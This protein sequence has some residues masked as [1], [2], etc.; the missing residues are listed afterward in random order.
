M[1]TN[2]YWEKD[3]A[4]PLLDV[5]LGRV[6]LEGLLVTR[7]GLHIG[8]GGSGDPMATDA[9][10][11]R[12]AAGEPFIP[13]SSLKGVVRS[14][15]ESLFRGRGQGGPGGLWSCDPITPGKACLTH[16][17]IDVLRKPFDR[18]PKDFD[19]KGFA[20]ALWDKSC[21][22]CRLFGS[23]G[24]AGRVRFPDLPLEGEL[25]FS[26]LRNGVGIDRDKELAAHGVL[27]DFEAI[28]PGTGFGLTVIVDNPCDAEIGLLLYLFQQLHEGHLGLGGKST[29]GLGQV[30]VHW[31][32]FQHITLEKGNPFAELVRQHTTEV[33]ARSAEQAEEPSDRLPKTGD[34]QTWEKIAELLPTLSSIDRFHLGQKAAA[35]GIDKETL[36]ETLGIAITGRRRA[37]DNVLEKLAESGFLVREGQDYRFPSREVAQQSPD[38]PE[39][40]PEFVKYRRDCLEAMSRLW[41]G[42]EA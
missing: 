30:A 3:S 13:G 26:E 41:S 23:A 15:A 1:N 25:L 17:K 35:E 24:M 21:T 11:V 10:V 39:L 38:E 37:W 9:P 22:V 27:Y 4:P 16:D 34:R 18:G 42:Q 32:R 2:G 8:A 40:D 28:P 14:A 20:K 19:S 29:R 6:R 7:T 12:N 5:F 33:E 31:K 36:G